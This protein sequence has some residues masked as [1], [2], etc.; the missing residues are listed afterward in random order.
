MTETTVQLKKILQAKS[1]DQP[2]EAEDILFVPSSAAKIA[3]ARTLGSGTVGRNRRD[4][5]GG[6]VRLELS[7]AAT[8][9]GKFL[10]FQKSLQ[11]LDVGPGSLRTGKV[12]QDMFAAVA[13]E[14]IRNSGSRASRTTAS[15]KSPTF[16]GWTKIPPWASSMIFLA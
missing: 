8:E 11:H 1:S 3:M 15:V 7:H 16:S 5:R 9:V 14:A 6:P 4:H 13:A 12:L 2:L 10:V